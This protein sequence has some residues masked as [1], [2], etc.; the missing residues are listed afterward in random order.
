MGLSRKDFIVK[1]GQLAAAGA[2][3]P[4]V[5]NAKDA[6][7]RFQMAL[8]QYSL[9]ALLKDGS[10]KAIDFPKYTVDTFG[11]KAIDL[12]EGG[13]PKDKLD[14]AAYLESMKK[15]AE[16]AGTDLFLLMTGTLMSDPKKAKNSI[17][18]ISKSLVRAERLGCRYLRIFLMA[19]NLEDAAS[20]LKTLCDQAAKHKVKI[21]IEP[22]PRGK[23]R[24]GAFL[25]ELHQ[26]V[27][28]PFLTLMPDFGKLKGNIYTGTEAMLPYSESISAK[29]HSFD[30]NGKQPDFDY[31]RLAKMI[32]DSKYKGYIA[33]EWEGKALKPVP[34]VKASQKL[35]IESFAKH[36]AK[37]I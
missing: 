23:G 11:I 6:E 20:A 21:I 33:I 35:V 29:M 19:V 7:A 14:D 15:S 32:V 31:D 22:T 26:K 1:G 24:E 5:L 13:L 25:A 36:G 28:H 8:S 34:G 12:W 18:N 2:L 3:L 9:R 27:N 30:A 4:S 37:V 10:L 17:A 16:T